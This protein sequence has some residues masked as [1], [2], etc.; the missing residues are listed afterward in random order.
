V[1]ALLAQLR[2]SFYPGVDF[3][4]LGGIARQDFGTSDRTTLRL[5]ADLKYQ[6]VA[7][8]APSQPAVSV[9]GAL[10]VETGDNFNVLTVGPTA[11]VSWTLSTG[12]QAAFTPYA[13]TGILFSNFNVD[14]LDDTDVSIPLRLGAELKV[15]PQ[16]DL[17]GEL[18]VRLSDDFNDDVGFSFGVNSSF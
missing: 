1:L 9:G 2:L 17:N 10:G 5:G 15:H 16:L 3:G 6:V 13:G 7:P 4:F 12:G 14:P 11:V 8:A 18:Q